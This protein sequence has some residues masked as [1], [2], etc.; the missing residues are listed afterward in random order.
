MSPHPKHYEWYQRSHKPSLLS[1]S[2][3][4][5]S[6]SDC[7][8]ALP[9]A[10]Q[11]LPREGSIINA[12]LRPRQSGGGRGGM[13]LSSSKVNKVI[14]L[15]GASVTAH[16]HRPRSLHRRPSGSRGEPSANR[17]FPGLDCLDAEGPAK[18]ELSERPTAPRLCPTQT[19]RGLSTLLPFPSPHSSRRRRARRMES[20]PSAAK[21]P[22]LGLQSLRAGSPT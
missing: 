22:G 8:R 11:L 21:P 15:R 1:E 4:N 13:Q 17:S 2:P 18:A 5:A 12:R 9:R 19:G 14:P 3:E 10:D 20:P 7:P 16:P 6:P